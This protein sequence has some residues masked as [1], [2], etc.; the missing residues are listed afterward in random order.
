[1]EMKLLAANLL[2]NFR[3]ALADPT[4]DIQFAAIPAF[5]PIHSDIQVQVLP[6][7]KY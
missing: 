1:M 5:Q 7:F 3:L 4:T 2:R 6:I